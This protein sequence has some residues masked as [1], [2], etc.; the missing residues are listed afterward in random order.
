MNVLLFQFYVV[1]HS[2]LHPSREKR[3]MPYMADIE[4]LNDVKD[5]VI[6]SLVTLLRNR[7]TIHDE[8]GDAKPIP[9]HKERPQLT[10][11]PE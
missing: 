1:V 8:G 6:T 11:T 5:D 10:S 7:A 4:V 2:I 9:H 3:V